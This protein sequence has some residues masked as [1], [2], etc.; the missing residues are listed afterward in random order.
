[1]NELIK[2]DPSIYSSV[3]LNTQLMDIR[4]GRRGQVFGT[5][6]NICRQYG[7]KC[8]K[9]DNCY[10]FTAPKLRLQLFIEKLH[11]SKTYYSKKM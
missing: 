6:E 7:I 8:I 2:K 10:E 1:M 3:S 11:F 5:V 9:H 4:M